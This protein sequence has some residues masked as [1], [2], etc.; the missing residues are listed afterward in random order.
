MDP[1][2]SDGS[3]GRARD[4]TERLLEAAV[5]AFAEHGFEAAT[6][7][8]IAR[9]AGLT[10][11]AIYARWPGKRHLIVDAVRYIV[12]QCMRLSPA[13]TEASA[14]ETLAQ[15]GADLVSTDNLMAREV[16][17]EA[18]VSARRD[19]SFRVAVSHSMSEEAAKLGAIVSRGKAAG[20]VKPD[21]ST[22][23]I[24]SLY[25]ALSLGMHLVISSQPEDSRVPA[26]EWEAL[27]S[28]LIEAMSPRS[29]SH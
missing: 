8:D 20:S 26:E 6:V 1:P 27:I 4:T 12:P 10:T 2:S 3:A 28:R 16:M 18:F 14:R 11:G 29:S 7:S 23:A 15:V 5:A 25:Q 17:L 9:R 13:D 19:D 24:V 21:L 22:D